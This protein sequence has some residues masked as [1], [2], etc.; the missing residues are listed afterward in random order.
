[1]LEQLKAQFGADV[2]QF[3]LGAAC[4]A[5][6]R[7]LWFA[8]A[9][10]RLLH[11]VRNEHAYR[12]HV[13]GLPNPDAFGFV[14]HRSYLVQG[15]SPRERALA[16][17]QHYRNESAALDGSYHE[18]VYH[19]G[20]LR[21]WRLEDQGTAFELRLMPGNDVLYEGGLSVTFF[22][23]GQRVAVLSYSNVDPALLGWGAP[24]GGPG[25]E[26]PGLVPF[27]ARRQSS[28]EEYRQAFTRTF[29]R[30]TPGHLAIAALEGI[31]LAQGSTR[32]L[33]IPARQHPAYRFTVARGCPGLENMYDGFWRSLSGEPG[34][35]A[36]SIPLP[37]QPTPLDELNSNN[38]RRALRLRAHQAAVRDAAFR[39]YRPHLR[40]DGRSRLRQVSGVRA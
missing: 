40:E 6:A 19:A 17:L 1:M 36:W 16:A 20:G 5:C 2:R 22:V 33:G 9:A 29:G 34:E 21:L 10:R 4:V 8:V 27:V 7:V 28:R 23:N 32:L 3:S 25:G 13:V 14:A 31:A 39:A 30:G 24:P 11:S 18:A 12:D 38:R 37:L 26:A 15:L 35:R